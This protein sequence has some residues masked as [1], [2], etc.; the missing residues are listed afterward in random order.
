MAVVIICKVDD[1][2]GSELEIRYFKHMIGYYLLFCL[3]DALWMPV[4]SGLVG[5]NP[6][7]NALLSTINM[8]S[9]AFLAYFWF[10]Y[11]QIRM[12]GIRLEGTKKLLV[13]QIPVILLTL[14]YVINPLTS[15]MFTVDAG[16]F[17]R[18]PLYY[19]VALLVGGYVL[20]V[21]VQA[22]YRMR[23]ASTKGQRS[24]YSTFLQFAIIPACAILIDLFVPNTP[25]FAL[26]V[27]TAILFVFSNLQEARIFNDS[28]TGL[29]N[30]RRADQYLTDKIADVDKSGAVYVYVLDVNLFKNIN[31]T[32]GHN[33][34]DHA[35]QVL[36]EGLR[37]AA[38]KS[39]GFVA[40]WGGDEFVLVADASETASPDEVVDLIDQNLAQACQDADL[41]YSITV[42]T[43]YA[44]CTSPNQNPDD[45]IM[46]ADRML[47][48]RKKEAHRRL[49]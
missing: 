48:E 33:E 30:R 8:F 13:S 14:L 20:L 46:Q 36:A 44:I 15:W 49:L 26:G 29:N 4:N 28:L 24:W 21:S 19:L 23:A 34:G 22:L 7:A 27:L 5:F 45:L 10:C 38:D 25:V 31:D 37:R 2:F 18:G 39:H 16:V 43:G 42:S 11:A 1:S 32:R 35:L 3:T 47:Y 12:G 9:L 6:S 17:V 40:R 41:P